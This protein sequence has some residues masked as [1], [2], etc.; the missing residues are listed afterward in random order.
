MTK[1]HD[2]EDLLAIANH[3]FVET[4]R[5]TSGLGLRVDSVDPENTCMKFKIRDDLTGSDRTVNLHGGVIAAVLDIT[6]SLVIFANL[7][8]KMKGDTLQKRVEKVTRLNTIDLRIDYLRPGIGNE[9]RATGYLL[10]TGKK[11]AVA[12]M[13]LH[14]EED[15]LIAVGTGSYILGVVSD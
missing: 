12:R 14:N 4:S 13:E 7:V 15:R 9:F 5:F 6:G 11:V 10:R 3:L 1:K 2:T 8:H